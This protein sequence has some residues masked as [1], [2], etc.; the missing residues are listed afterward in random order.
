MLL[1][2]FL[3]DFAGKPS[4]GRRLYRLRDWA[5]NLADWVDRIRRVRPLTH[6]EQAEVATIGGMMRIELAGCREVSSR[7]HAVQTAAAARRVTAEWGNL[8]G[9]TDADI[10]A[11]VV[12]VRRPDEI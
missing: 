8:A 7:L 1:V 2:H 4:F 11:V 5:D 6:D 3:P 9:E 10:R 12:D